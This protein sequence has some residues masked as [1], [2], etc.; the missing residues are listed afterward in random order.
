MEA[1]GVELTTVLTARKLLILGTART[2][3][4]VL[5]PEPLYVYCTKSFSLWARQTPHVPQ[6]PIDSPW[7]NWEKDT[8][9]QTIRRNV[10]QYAHKARYWE[11]MAGHSQNSTPP[12]VKTRNG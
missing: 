6:Y 10:I 11:A 12:R 2:A 5:L 1:A 4:K 8:E 7:L 3:K 9:P